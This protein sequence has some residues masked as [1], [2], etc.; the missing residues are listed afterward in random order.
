MFDELVQKLDLTLKKLRGMGKITES[1]IADSMRE[2]RRV[3]LEADVN[4]KVVRDFVTKVQSRAIGQDV[5]RSITPGQQVVKVVFDE[6]V[7]LLGKAN[8]PI[9]FGK[10][11][12]AVIM[13]VGLQ[14]SGKTTFV[15]K[16]GCYLRKLGRQPLLVAADVYRPAAVEQLQTLGK[17]ADLAV[18]SLAN[19]NPLKI[20][21]ESVNHA[22]KNKLDTL[23]LDTA[24]RLHIDEKMMAELGTIKEAVRPCE[25]LFVADSM[26]GQDAV[27]SATAFL[28]Q[29]DF[30][31]IVLTKLDGDAKGGAALSI[32]AVTEK[33]VKFITN[34]EK[35]DGLESFHPDRM[36]SRILGMGDVVTLVEKARETVSREDAEKLEKKLGKK[37]FTLEDF[38]AQLQQIKSMGS[39]NQIVGMLPGM[40]NRLKGLHVDESALTRI[41]VIINS[42][43]REERRKPH[44]LNGSRRKRVAAGSGTR[45]QDVNQLIKQFQMMQNMMKQMG[46]FQGKRMP[47]NIPFAL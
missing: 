31:G 27:K 20:V 43:T 47:R 3:L 41:E 18:F 42:M 23:I 22:S 32:T 33:P 7:S 40:G 29:I 1:N 44:I 5:I 4:Y 39:L 46:R 10:Q 26:T 21:Q 25:I 37:D 13:V 36:A 14:G 17:S 16:L 9:Q 15:G 45:V 2:I 35:L 12:P 24:G 19:Q 38:Y 34:N 11:H 8:V 30:D 28:E 6:M